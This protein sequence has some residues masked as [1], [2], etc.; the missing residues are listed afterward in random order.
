MMRQ[1]LACLAGMFLVAGCSLV[2]G[3]AG[4]LDTEEQA[5]ERMTALHDDLAGVAHPDDT[6]LVDT[7]SNVESGYFLRRLYCVDM[8][9]QEVRRFYQEALPNAGWVL[10]RARDEEGPAEFSKEIGGLEAEA[11]VVS[12]K[13]SV[14]IDEMPECD[15]Q[16]YVIEGSVPYQ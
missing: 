12:V 7:F 2:T 15:R 11:S 5:S 14:A 1:M 9:M 13:E 8:T 10:R 16:A 4:I 6:V 3:P